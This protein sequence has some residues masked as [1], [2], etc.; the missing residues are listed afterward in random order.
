VDRSWE[1]CI[2]IAHRH[3]N[4]EI[5]TEKMRFPEQE[6][7]NGQFHCSAGGAGNEVCKSHYSCTSGE[8]TAVPKS[9]RRLPIAVQLTPREGW[10]GNLK[11]SCRGLSWY[12]NELLT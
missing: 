10:V 1:Y 9:K 4:V 2:Q 7:I 11:R 3:M 12:R 5:G 8:R 6:Y